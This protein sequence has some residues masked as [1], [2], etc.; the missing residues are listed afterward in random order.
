MI[1]IN[2][3]H[4][5]AKHWNL[6]LSEILN[7]YLTKISNALYYLHYIFYIPLH[8]NV[9]AWNT[10]INQAWAGTHFNLA[11]YRTAGG[12]GAPAPY[13]ENRKRKMSW[14]PHCPLAIVTFILLNL[15]HIFNASYNSKLATSRKLHWHFIDQKPKILIQKMLTLTL[16]WPVWPKFWP[17]LRISAYIGQHQPFSN[18]R[19]KDR[20][21]R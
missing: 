20:A 15:H 19:T 12:E 21:E 10:Y 7:I 6:K 1:R 4:S 9:Q 11:F 18:G 5:S 2:T 8:I 16:G 3:T 17:Y 14:A 13:G